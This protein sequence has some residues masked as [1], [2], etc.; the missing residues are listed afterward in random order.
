MIFRVCDHYEDIEI[1]C[2]EDEICFVCYDGPSLSKPMMQLRNQHKYKANC[3]CNGP[4]HEACL[5]DWIQHQ[6][7]CPIC[8]SNAV[9]VME[10]VETGNNHSHRH[11]VVVWMV[12]VVFTWPLWNRLFTY[13]DFKR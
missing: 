4:I 2:S 8:R 6:H 7:K 11:R 10:T 13:F 12:Y 3:G 1:N 9:L 5:T